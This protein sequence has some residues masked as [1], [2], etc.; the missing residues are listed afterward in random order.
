MR[1][2]SLAV[3]GSACVLFALGCGKKVEPVARV[4]VSGAVK[5]DGKDVKSGSIAFDAQ[6]GQPPGSMS[7]LDGRYDGLAPVGKCKVTINAV[8]KM[9]TKEWAR[10]QGKPAMDGPGYDALQEV[11]LLPARYNAKSEITREVTEPGPHVFDFAELKG[12]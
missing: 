11:N 12:K 4:K 7:V 1:P 3:V 6:N 9:M 5:V 8:E 10:K 2:F